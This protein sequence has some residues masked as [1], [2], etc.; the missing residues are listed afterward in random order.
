MS[1]TRHTN[2]TDL[3]FSSPD[4]LVSNIEVI[5]PFSTSDYNTISFN[6]LSPDA[7]TSENVASNSFNFPPKY[8]FSKIDQAGFS[9][10]L[11]TIDWH[12]CFAVTDNIDVAWENFNKLLSS[13]IKRFTP[14]KKDKPIKSLSTRPLPL[15]IL[16]LINQKRAAWKRYSKH[17]SVDNRKIFYRLAKTVRKSL[18]AFHKVREENILCNGSVIKFFNYARSHM[19]P[20]HSLGPLKG[21]NDEI[22]NNDLEKANLLN[23]YF[24]SVY[25][26]DDG[27]FPPF[28]SR[29]NINLPTPVFSVTDVRKS[30]LSSSSS[31]SCGPDGVPPILLKKFPELSLPLCDLFNMSVQQGCVP[32]AWRSAN[33]IPVYKGKG[34]T[35]EVN[36]YRPISLTNVF[37]KSLE[38][39]IRSSIITHL[40][41][42]KLLSNCQFGFRSGLSTLTQLTQG[43]IFI[44]DHINQLRCVDG[45]YTDLSKA[46]DS[47]SHS[48]LLLKLQA[49]GISGPILCWIKSFIIGRTQSVSVNSKLSTQKPCTS[50]VPQGSILSPLLFILF[51]NDLPDYISYSTIFLYA[52][53]AKLLKPITCLSDCIHLQNDLDS[54]AAWCSLW[55]LKLNIAK[56]LWS[57]F[58]QANKPIFS[59]SIS[60]TELKRVNAVNDLGVTF[61]SKLDFSAHCHKLAA[62][63]YARVNMLLKCFHS[64][65]RSLQC[66]L[67][68]AF[69]LPVLMYNS[70]IWSPHY[71]KDILVIERVQKFF[72]KN[73]KGMQNKSYAERLSI[74]KLPTLECRRTYADIIFLYKIIHGLSSI[75]LQQ[76]FPLAISNSNLVLRHHPFQLDLPRPRTNL[77]KFS[78]RYRAAN[79]WNKLPS[80]ISGASSIYI[81]KKL[82]MPYICTFK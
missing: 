71:V 12:Q 60:G 37:C 33:V 6:F 41:P 64:K 80:Q 14:L 55:Q 49:Y 1:P 67:Y 57:R 58:G 50:G 20:K 76:F 29:T 28:P 5:I 48:K 17:K 72:T 52:D 35:L 8:D 82:L 62:K 32:T 16:Q 68:S 79:L 59:Y 47:I 54:F 22:I 77:L 7:Q 65:D 23:D 39:L 63:G 4:D 78:F 66:K 40:E 42:Y 2:L 43:Q 11:L 51:I 19:S 70:P 45:V 24:H 3:L 53:D 69:V 27:T 31:I 73:L 74:L 56:C 75:Y 36:N 18:E 25:I 13:L 61:D 34:S 38:R 26:P 21:Q 15:N 44:N 81:F 46:F 10:S 9:A 30:L